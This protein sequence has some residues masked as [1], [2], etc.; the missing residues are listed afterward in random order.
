MRNID[1]ENGHRGS[2]SIGASM[3]PSMLVLPSMPKGEIGTI[4]GQLVVIDVN[5]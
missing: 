1:E 3:F 4:V 5:P 2:M